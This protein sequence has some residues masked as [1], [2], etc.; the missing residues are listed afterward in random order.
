[1]ADTD[2]AQGAKPKKSLMTPLLLLLVLGNTGVA[3]GG[4]YLTHQLMTQMNDVR[5]MVEAQ[6]GDVEV[7]VVEEEVVEYNP[8]L[9]EVGPVTVNMKSPSVARK[10][11]LL[12]ASFLFRSD[13]EVTT[14]LI[15]DKSREINNSL[16]LL[17]SDYTKDDI[18]SSEGKNRLTQSIIAMMEANYKETHPDLAISKVLFSKFIIQ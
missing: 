7:E 16:I 10:S 1:M 18:I 17:L 9:V 14:K 13:N 6:N 11:N 8:V 12:Y 3:A 15:E 5:S 4:A 2:E